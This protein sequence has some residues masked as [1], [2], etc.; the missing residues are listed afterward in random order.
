MPSVI[1]IITLIPEAA[2]SRIAS[3]AKAGGTKITDVL[4][5]V[6]LTASSTVLNT[7]TPTW[8]VPPLPGVTPATTFVPYS[9]ICSVWK[10]PSL[11]V[12]PCTTRRVLLLINI[13]IKKILFY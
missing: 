9:I 6:C 5:F 12:M 2:A 10:D 11:P 1:Q 8:S 7:G 4:A 3:A 13:A